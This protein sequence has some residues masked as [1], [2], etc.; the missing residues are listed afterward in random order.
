M[1]GM[2]LVNELDLAKLE[3]DKYMFKEAFSCTTKKLEE[4]LNESKR[5]IDGMSYCL[6]LL[7]RIK[8]QY[9][10][11]FSECITREDIKKLIDF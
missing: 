1:L 7:G 2:K 3:S 5:Y 4:V 9:P 10:Y 6:K 8:E 11:V